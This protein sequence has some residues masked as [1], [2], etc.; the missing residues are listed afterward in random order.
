MSRRVLGRAIVVAALALSCG[1]REHFHGIAD[2]GA[3]EDG[4]GALEDG[5]GVE[6]TQ[7]GGSPQDGGGSPHGM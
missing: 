2:G 7:D 3:L 6:P 1:G 4:G 5:G